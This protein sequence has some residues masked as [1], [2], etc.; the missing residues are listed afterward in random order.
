MVTTFFPPY[1]FGGDAVFVQRLAGEL[2]A[3]GHHVE[4]IHCVDSYHLLRGRK[5]LQAAPGR[6]TEGPVIHG[7]RSRLGPLSPLATHQTGRPLG[8]TRRIE[9][10]LD[11][12]FDVIHFHNISLIG[13]PG[14]LA[15]GSA[16]KLYTMHEAW[17]VC[18]T[19][20]LF[21]MRRQPCERPTC[22]RC[23]L[24]H[25]R[26]PQLWRSTRRLAAGLEH[27]DAF[28]APSRYC[29]DLHRSRGLALPMVRIPNFVPALDRTLS[30]EPDR[31]ADEP[32]LLFVGRLERLKGLHTVIPVFK[33]LRRARLV[34]AG[35]G[36][37]E[38]SLRNLAEDAPNI[39]F[40]SHCDGEK[41]QSL[42]RR[43][44]ALIVPSLVPEVFPLVILEAFRQ[45]TPALVRS[46]GAL[47][48]IIAESGGGL[49]FSSTDELRSAVKIVL[50]DR[51]ERGRLGARGRST[52][53]TRWSPDAHVDRYLQLIED[54]QSGRP[55]LSSTS[56]RTPGAPATDLR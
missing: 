14:V 24:A 38:G 30:P 12:G 13:G 19:H 31:D 56:P 27:V 1:G 23:T 4:V 33:E 16:V 7:L 47:P 50:E 10:I 55:V 3:R 43:A 18:P 26:P 53:E 39:S 46:I 5:Q 52:V 34:I 37:Q 28:I 49:V 41:L 44:A 40:L 2:H 25:R 22:L 54:L 45:G 9:G 11:R 29:R 6:A 36:S 21:K 48:E 17:L 15:L 8:K 51:E 20:V 42:Y 32:Y 35:A